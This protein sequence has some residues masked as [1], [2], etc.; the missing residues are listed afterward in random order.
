MKTITLNKQDFYADHFWSIKDGRA[1]R[2]DLFVQTYLSHYFTLRDIYR[3]AQ[4]VGKESLLNYARQVGNHD[5]I[6]HLLDLI[7]RH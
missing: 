6:K 4:M 7:D 3:L 1:I 5:R 2:E